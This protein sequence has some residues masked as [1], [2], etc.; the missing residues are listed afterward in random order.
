[1]SSINNQMS[2]HEQ[3]FLPQSL[4]QTSKGNICTR[5]TKQPKIKAEQ[6]ILLYCDLVSSCCEEYSTHLY[7]I[8]SPQFLLQGLELHDLV[9]FVLGAQVP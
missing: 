5:S 3:T 2:F 9:V 7:L 4:E 8:Q 1:M 6:P